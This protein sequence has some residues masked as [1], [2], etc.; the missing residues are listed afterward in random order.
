MTCTLQS[1]VPADAQELLE[2]LQ[3][4][5]GNAFG[6]ATPLTKDGMTTLVL[7]PMASHKYGPQIIES[8][9]FKVLCKDWPD[10]S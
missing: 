9:G 8:S 6:S 10:K 2:R 4:Q 3:G 7:D 1:P 5:L